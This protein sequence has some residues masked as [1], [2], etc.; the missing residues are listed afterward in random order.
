M[1]F[2]L[3]S[4]TYPSAPETHTHAF[5]TESSSSAAESTKTDSK[6]RGQVPAGKRNARKVSDLTLPI[7]GLGGVEGGWLVLVGG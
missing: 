2:I 3:A 5:E 4:P 7:R 1:T 6:Y